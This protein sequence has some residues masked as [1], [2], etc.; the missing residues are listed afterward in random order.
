[1][2]SRINLLA[3]T[4]VLVLLLPF[5][6]HREF[7]T[8]ERANVGAL[9]LL[10]G[11]VLKTNYWV[12][13]LAFSPDGSMLV[14]AGGSMD[15]QAELIAW[16]VAR[17]EKQ[18]ALAGHRGAVHSVAF[19]ADG[20]VLASASLDDT[21]GFWD[22]RSGALK[23]TLPI[24]GVVYMALSPDGRR[25]A[26]TGVEKQVSLWE[27]A[28]GKRLHAFPGYGRPAFAP[29]GR[30][31]ALGSKNIIQRFDVETGREIGRWPGSAAAVLAVDYSP[32]G[33]RLAVI[34]DHS[35][36]VEVWDVAGGRLEGTL[37]GQ[38]EYV[39]ALAFARDGCTLASGGLDRT[40]RLWDLTSGRLLD[41]GNGH[42]ARIS[43]LAFAPDGLHLVSAGYDRTVRF[44]R[45]VPGRQ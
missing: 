27:V 12:D 19:S 22:P 29:D 37:V 20:S 39:G 26:T 35:P 6:L 13:H 8:R 24:E 40:V 14:T 3:S 32:D 10:P 5:V 41:A 44:W 16:E 7:G 18:F 43:A 31:L 38:D 36:A 11:R 45:I 25:L 9:S 2:S 21:V 42:S 1:M 4:W 28:T 30:T 23:A 33:R 17:G 34:G 15:R